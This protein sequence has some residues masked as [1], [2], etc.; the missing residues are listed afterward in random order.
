MVT[1][2]TTHNTTVSL[3]FYT[4][5]I[6]NHDYVLAADSIK[7]ITSMIQPNGT[8]SLTLPTDEKAVKYIVYASYY[9]LTGERA[10]V[11]GPNPQNFVQNG[12][13]VVDHFSSVGAK[14]TTDFLENYVLI[15]GVK[16][17]LKEVGNYSTYFAHSRQNKPRH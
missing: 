16:E 2:E 3:S 11:A 13:F 15:N 12:S 9:V 4:Y 14:V 8:I 7:D 10:C 5:T 1:N 6:T 17:L